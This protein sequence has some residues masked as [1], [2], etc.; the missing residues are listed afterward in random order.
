V[1]GVENVVA[2]A[3]SCPSGHGGVGSEPGSLTPGADLSRVAT[4]PGQPDFTRPSEPDSS[5]AQVLTIQHAAG[6]DS[7]AM[8][9]EQRRCGECLKM[10]QSEVLRVCALDA[11]A[12]ELLCDV[13]MKQ[14]R[15]LVPAE[16]RQKVF[17]AM[18]AL[19][20]PGIRASKRLSRAVSC[21]QEWPVMSQSFAE[22]AYSAIRARFTDM[23]DRQCSQL[24][25][26]R[27]GLHISTW[28]WLDLFRFLQVAAGIFLQL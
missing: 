10:Q 18:H 14:L 26:R 22:I 27:S 5:P 2:D 11:G 28:I 15:P 16:Y 3:L 23:S 19:A 7:A 20:H 12:C 13:S 8:A 24:S 1:P 21:G 4:C 25:C 6:I 9:A 17:A